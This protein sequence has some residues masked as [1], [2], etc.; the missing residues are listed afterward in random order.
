MT[1]ALGSVRP[2]RC[3]AQE[4]KKKKSLHRTAQDGGTCIS[5]RRVLP[6]TR[7]KSQRGSVLA[8]SLSFRPL[9]TSSLQPS[10]FLSIAAELYQLI[11]QSHHLYT[12]TRSIALLRS[13]CFSARPTS[14]SPSCLSL[15]CR[16]PSLPQ[17]DRL[18]PTF[19]RPCHLPPSEL[20]RRFLQASHTSLPHA[21]QP[22]LVKARSTLTR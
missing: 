9:F 12:L 2:A 5:Q 11:A 4:S 15:A 21:R 8:E 1:V 7:E 16:L 14:L 20:D 10:F 22:S 3:G 13:T 19:A 18:S 6:R 17:L